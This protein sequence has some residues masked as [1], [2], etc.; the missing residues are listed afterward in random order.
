M[1]SANFN[2]AN[3]MLIYNSAISLQNQRWFKKLNATNT[4]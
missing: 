1:P 4:T 3:S 2:S